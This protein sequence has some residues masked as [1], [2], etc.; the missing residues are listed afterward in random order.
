[1]KILKDSFYFI[2]FWTQQWTQNERSKLTRRSF[3]RP[4]PSSSRKES[5]GKHPEVK[6]RAAAD[7][8]ASTGLYSWKMGSVGLEGDI[9][10]LSGHQRLYAQQ[11]VVFY[12]LLCGNSLGSAV[13]GRLW[14]VGINGVGTISVEPQGER[15][16]PWGFLTW[17]QPAW[18]GFS[19]CLWG[20]IRNRQL[21]LGQCFYERGGMPVV[22]QDPQLVVLVLANCS[23]HSLS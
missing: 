1:M 18:R 6:A 22:I 10:D 4:R 2:G 17:V 11:R 16:R 8:G 5:H 14:T 13:Q 12:L 23:V 7:G 9:W 19:F 15:E 21:T 3:T 20:L